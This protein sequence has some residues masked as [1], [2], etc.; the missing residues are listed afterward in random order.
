MFESSLINC[1]MF[2][3]FWTEVVRVFIQLEARLRPNIGNTLSRVSTWF[4]R[5]AITPPEVNRFE[6][7]LGHSDNIVA[8]SGRFWARS[9]QKREWESEAKFCFLSGK[10]RRT[11]P[12]SGRPSFTKFAHKTW[13]GVAM[14]PFGTKFWK[15]PRKGSFF[16]KRKF[17]AKI[18]NDLRLQALITP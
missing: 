17:F 4:M 6:W 8:G 13:T 18:F 1:I 3:W 9:A 2:N 15:C 11:L 16:Q 7:N 5:S 10:Q 14:N 12:I